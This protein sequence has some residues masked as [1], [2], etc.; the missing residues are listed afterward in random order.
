MVDQW[1]FITI[2]QK[3]LSDTKQGITRLH[4]IDHLH[5]NE[6]K[7]NFFQ[8]LWFQTQSTAKLDRFEFKN[9]P[10]ISQIA[11]ADHNSRFRIKSKFW[12]IN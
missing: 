10:I 12:L 2:T 4:H 8:E 11:F 7:F 6:V 3:P 1:P 5:E 9:L